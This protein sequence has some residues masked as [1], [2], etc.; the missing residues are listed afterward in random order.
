[1]GKQR[2]IDIIFLW[3]DFLVMIYNGKVIIYYS[4]VATQVIVT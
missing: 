3:V 4:P 2:I 1:M